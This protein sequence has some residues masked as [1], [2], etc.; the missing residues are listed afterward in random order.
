MLSN[1]GL[2]AGWNNIFGFWPYWS[3]NNGLATRVT[4]SD[5]DPILESAL[6]CPSDDLPQTHLSSSAKTKPPVTKTTNNAANSGPWLIPETKRNPNINDS[7]VLAGW[8]FIS[9]IFAVRET[10]NKETSL[11]RYY[12]IVVC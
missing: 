9:Q 6:D 3:R 8:L 10:R 12:F 5:D 11:C 7:I 2:S 4:S 1:R